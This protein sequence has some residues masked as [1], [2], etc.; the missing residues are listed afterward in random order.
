MV[1]RLILI[2]KYLKYRTISLYT[3]FSTCRFY[4]TKRF[5]AML[6]NFYTKLKVISGAHGMGFA[7]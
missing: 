5:Q 3:I 1:Y 2:E 7:Y 6:L 4:Q